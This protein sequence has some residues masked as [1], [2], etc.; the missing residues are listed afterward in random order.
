MTGTHR[1]VDDA[2]AAAYSETGTAW[3][4]GPGRIY[5]VLARHLVASI[6]IDPHDLALDLGAGTGAA[7]RVLRGAGAHVIA[8]DIALGMLH[9]ITDRVSCVVA[10][11]R[12]LPFAPA[13]FD[14]VAAAFSLNHVTDPVRSLIEVRRVLRRGGQFAASVYAADD[15][16]PVKRAV[17]TAAFDMGWRRPPWYDELAGSAMPTLATVDRAEA[18]LGAAGLDGDAA[19][20]EVPIVGVTPL[21]MVEWRLGMAQL[22]PFVAALDDIQ[23]AAL[24]ERAHQLLGPSPAPLVRR[25]VQLRAVR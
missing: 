4:A 9:A 21:E 11:V 18:A 15:D 1:A 12:V 24:R 17:E 2:I 23:R 22:A 5:D 25:V 6:S 19:A 14:V 13:T 20:V 10:D 3:Q 7:S 16:H 8:L